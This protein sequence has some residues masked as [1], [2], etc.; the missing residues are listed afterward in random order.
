MAN[1]LG[2]NI[3]CLSLH[4]KTYHLEEGLIKKALAAE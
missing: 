1:D 2:E 3:S 4:L